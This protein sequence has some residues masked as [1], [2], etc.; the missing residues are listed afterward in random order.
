MLGQEDEERRTADGREENQNPTCFFGGPPLA[1]VDAARLSYDA[2]VSQFMEPGIPVIIKGAASSWRA[3]REWASRRKGMPLPLAL[4]AAASPG[5][6]APVVDCGGGGSG[7][8][9]T[10]SRR[11]GEMAV[12]EFAERW[13]ASERGGG[14]EEEAEGGDSRRLYLKDWHF[15]LTLKTERSG[16]DGGGGEASP[17]APPSPPSPALVGG[18]ASWYSVPPYFRD[19]WLNGALLAGIRLRGGAEN[20]DENGGENGGGEEEEK[21]KVEDDFRFLYAGPSQTTTLLH[22]DVLSSCSWSANVAGRKRWRLIAPEKTHLLFDRFGREIA[23]DFLISSA[24]SS[25]SS[26]SSSS[27]PLLHL[28]SRHISEVIQEPGDAIFVPPGWHH[29]VENLGKEGEEE[30]EEEDDGGDGERGDGGEKSEM[31]SSRERKFE[32]ENQLLSCGG[33]ISINH[34]WFNAHSLHWVLSLLR[35]ERRAAVEAIEDCR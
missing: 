19:D 28:A 12:R 5:A 3:S 27:F 33:A 26:S 4:A 35:G 9:E 30:E 34:N 20:G 8:A 13:V 32:E 25:S 1:V 10:K 31:G 24:P 7:E 21:G 6:D 18:H 11:R 2:F 15:C 17:L 22:A 29:T 23:P 14:E 16:G